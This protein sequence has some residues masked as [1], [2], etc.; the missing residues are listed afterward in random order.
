M[1]TLGYASIP[2]LAFCALLGAFAGG[3]GFT[4]YYA[5]GYSYLSNDPVA[6]VNCHIMR[7]QFDS[8]MGSSHRNVAVCNDCHI[9][10]TFPPKYLVKADN[11]FWARRSTTPGRGRWRW[12]DWV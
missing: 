11:G 6:C 3:G 4:F 2:L 7:E 1:K 9:P 12:P 8:W 5:K 10:H